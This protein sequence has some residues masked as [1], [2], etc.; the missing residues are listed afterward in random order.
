MTHVQH[1]I[2]NDLNYSANG[3]PM[4]RQKFDT[5]VT[6]IFEKGSVSKVHIHGYSQFAPGEEQK[7]YFVF[8]RAIVVTVSNPI[9]IKYT[10]HFRG[11]TPIE[12]IEEI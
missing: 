11:L 5:M 12:I 7:N 4:E 10:V 6:E 1:Y 2:P 8:S 9:E 3:Y